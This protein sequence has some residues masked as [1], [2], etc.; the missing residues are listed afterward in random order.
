MEQTNHFTCIKLG[1]VRIEY[2]NNEPLFYLSGNGLCFSV[3]DILAVVSNSE[4][5]NFAWRLLHLLDKFVDSKHATYWTLRGDIAVSLS[6]NKSL[7]KKAVRYG[8]CKTYLMKDENTGFVKIGKSIHP[9]KRESTLQ[10]E[11]PVIS[12]FKVCDKLIESELHNKFKNKRI[13]GEWFDLTKKDITYIL[14]NYDFV[15]K[16]IIN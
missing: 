3:W 8:K 1:A 6:R 5:T 12:L 14:S 7:Y 4:D 16:E 15:D 2:K 9:Q 10:S 13:R 11:K